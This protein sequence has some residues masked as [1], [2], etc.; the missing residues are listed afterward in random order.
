VRHRGG[1]RLRG[2]DAAYGEAFGPRV[3]ISRQ[4]LHAPG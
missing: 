1:L 4:S 3:G 2:D